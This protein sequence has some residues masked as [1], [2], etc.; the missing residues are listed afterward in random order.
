MSRGGVG[1]SCT[2]VERKEEGGQSTQTVQPH[3]HGVEVNPF[4]CGGEP[5]R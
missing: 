1:S 4:V 2:R 5:S 3:I